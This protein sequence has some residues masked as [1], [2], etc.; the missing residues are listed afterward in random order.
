MLQHEIAVVCCPA[1]LLD[2]KALTLSVEQLTIL[3]N[4]HFSLQEG[5]F[6]GIV[7]P[8]GAGKSSLLKVIQGELQQYQGQLWLRDQLLTKLSLKQRARKIATVSQT[9][10]PLFALTV[11]Q[12]VEMGL[13]PR[14]NWFDLTSNEDKQLIDKT[15]TIVG[16]TQKKDHYLHTLSG[17]EQQRAYIAR[18]L[19]Q[20][21]QILLLDEPTNHLDIRYQHQILQ[22]IR[23]Q[24]IGVLACLHDLNLAAYYCDKILLLNEG[25]QCALGTP[26]QV[27]QPG[28]L[29]QVFKV[30]CQVLRHPVSMKLQITFLPQQEAQQC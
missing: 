19:I 30:P 27:L 21:P 28:L 2:V 29:Q 24:G 10:E 4:I 23:Q 15:L 3:E 5:E 8:N 20:Q 25:Q 22:L 6:F 18:A 26:E 17:G 12:V 1:S 16:L 14:K 7:G 13:I 9:H 11:Y